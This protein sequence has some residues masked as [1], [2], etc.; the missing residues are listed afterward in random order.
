MLTPV[1]AMIGTPP[2]M[3]PEQFDA[4]ER[5]D[6]RADV[7]GLGCA[8]CHAI[9]GKPA[10]AARNMTDLIV[11]KTAMRGS[12]L[13]VELPGAPRE[14]ADFVARMLAADPDDRPADH[15]A[16][17]AGL[18]G[19]LAQLDGAVAPKRRGAIWATVSMARVPRDSCRARMAPTAC[20][21][22]RPGWAS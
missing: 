7:Y 15:G 8:L 4:P 2:T 18:Q 9:G 1:G 6:Q 14:V 13:R 5:V 20:S 16:V 17:I 12:G 3:A 21:T 19:L 11:E 10:F 22:A